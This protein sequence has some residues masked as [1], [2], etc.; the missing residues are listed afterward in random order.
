MISKSQHQNHLRTYVFEALVIVVQTSSEVRICNEFYRSVACWRFSVPAH[1]E[2]KQERRLSNVFGIG[3]DVPPPTPE[4]RLDLNAKKS[5]KKKKKQKKKR[6]GSTEMTSM[7][8]FFE[9]E[10][11]SPKSRRA[12]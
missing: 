5:N 2:V 9:R 4:H 12:K 1:R 7:E 6:K 8:E 10:D 11:G 3:G